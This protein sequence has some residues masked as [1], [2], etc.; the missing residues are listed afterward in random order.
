MSEKWAKVVVVLRVKVSGGGGWHSPEKGVWGCV[1]HKSS[2]LRLSCRSQLHK[3]PSW[4][5]SPLTSPYLKDKCK[6][7]SPKSTFL[8]NMAIFISRSSNL[9]LIFVKKLRNYELSILK[10]LFLMKVHSQAPLW[11]Q[12]IRSQAPKF[13]NLV[14]TYL[15]EK[16]WV[17]SPGWWVIVAEKIAA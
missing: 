2:F 5:L 7:L 11:W 10:P 16:S 8:E 4:G 15:P 9:A 17:P 13:Q 14:H 3:T 12:F 6:F 1:A